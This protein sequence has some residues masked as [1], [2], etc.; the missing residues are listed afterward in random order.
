MV[1]HL[2]GYLRSFAGN[3]SELSVDGSPTTV[4]Q[5]LTVV[6][7]AWPGV[8][9]RVVDEQ[10]A[11]RQHVNIFVGDESIR[12]LDGLDTKLPPGADIF[13]LPAVSGG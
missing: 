3:R 12:F 10:G 9:D 4:G 6:F 11:V 7:A 1:V 8:R 13:I 5:A 2:P